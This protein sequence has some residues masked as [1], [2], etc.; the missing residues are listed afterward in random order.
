[1]IVSQTSSTEDVLRAASL[2]EAAVV[3]LF[4]TLDDLAAAPRILT[5]CCVT[6]GSRAAA[7]RWR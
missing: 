3:P 2:T 1:V 4:E 6:S 7:R 5:S